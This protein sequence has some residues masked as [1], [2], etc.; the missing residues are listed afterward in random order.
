MKTIEF[1]PENTEDFN[2]M[3]QNKVFYDTVYKHKC[4]ILYYNEE[5]IV[6]KYSLK[7]RAWFYEARDFESFKLIYC[8]S[9]NYSSEKNY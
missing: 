3:L 2:K 7:G 1:T 9:R 8:F 6:W 5:Y 4:H